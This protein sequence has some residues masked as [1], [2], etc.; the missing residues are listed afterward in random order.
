MNRA[1]RAFDRADRYDAHAATQHAVA[2]AL[3]ERIAALDLPR[4]PRVLEIGC[5]TG[6]LTEALLPRIGGLWTVTDLAPAMLDR[7]H[8]RI[9]ER[10]D[11]RFRTMDGERPDL[12]HGSFDLI[13][14]SLAFQ[15]FADLPGAIG[16]L[17]RLLAPG[18]RL[19]FAT[20]AENSFAE[21][22]RAF[23]EAGLPAATPDYP[24]AEALAAMIP[25]DAEGGIAEDRFV[26]RH[27][28]ARAFLAALRGI[29]AQSP[30]E[31]HRPLPIAALRRVMA[32]FDASGA[33]VTYHVA[34][35]VIT[36]TALRREAAA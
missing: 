26:E 33:S 14:S 5:G 23:A 18:G 12:P 24:S 2:Q 28:D 6:F 8:A 30:R 25:G 21:W 15:W 1:I 27:A 22:R 7:C 13:C 11:V 9:G 19:L 29:G 17:T 16:R 35:G 32:A 10:D 20:M 3:A 31:G 36:R 4:A 34:Y